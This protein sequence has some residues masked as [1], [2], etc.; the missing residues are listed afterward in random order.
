MKKALLL[1]VLAFLCAA[2]LI[3]PILAACNESGETSDESS[4]EVS[5]A[6]EVK[7]VIIGEKEFSL[8]DEVNSELTED[9]V[10]IYTAESGKAAMPKKDADD[11]N[12]FDAVVLDG[13]VVAIYDSGSTAVIPENGYVIRF[14]GVEDAN[15]NLGDSVE[16][17]SLDVP[18][19]PEKCVRFGDI[20][21]EIGYENAERTAEDTG[22]LYNEHW[23]TGITESNVYCTE[24]AIKDG[25]IVEINRSG[26]DIAGISIPE[27]GYVLVVGQGSINERKVSGLNVGDEAELIYGDNLYTAK[28]YGISGTNRTRPEDGI[29]L[30]TREDDTTTTPVGNNLTEIVVDKNGVMT[31]VYPDCVGM[32]KI[33]EDGFIISATDLAATTIARNAVVGGKVFLSGN[34]AIVI[35]TDPESELVR[36][37]TEFAVIKESFEA[38]VGR[39][40]HI[41]FEKAAGI[42]RE[43]NANI[44][45]ADETLGSS[46]IADIEYNGFDGEVLAGAISALET[47]SVQGRNE[48]VP[49]ITVQDRMAWVT[50]GEYD[51]SNKLMLHYTSQADVDHTVAYAKSIGLNTL[52]IDNLVIGFSVYESEVPG[53]IKLPQ[54]GEL[55]LIEAFKTACDKNGLRLIVMV[56]AFSSGLDKV[57][58]PKDHYMKLY[59]DKYLLTNK[60]NNV[61]ID[62]VI[63]LDPADKDVQAFNLAIISEIVEKYDVYGVQ[64]D[65]MRYPLPNYY[66]EHNYEDFGYN[67][68][69]TSGFIKKYG[70]DPAKLSIT[71]PL[72]EKWCAWR[73]DIISEYQKN[74]YQTVKAINPELHVSFTCFAD[75]RDRQLY[76]YQDVEK[77]A[78]NGYA[79]AILP[80]IYGETTEY[81]LG[82][83]EE[84]LPVTEHTRLVLGVG[85]YVKATHE[86]I[87]EQF[88]MPYDLCA[89]GVA[90]FTL[91]YISICGYDETV[92]NAFRAAAT[93]T[94]APDAE[95]I[96]ASV[97]MIVN[98]VK[99]LKFA[100]EYSDSLTD[101]EGE[102]LNGIADRVGTLTSSVDFDTFCAELEALR[103]SIETGEIAVSELV[104]TALLGELDYIISLN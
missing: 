16:C 31:G 67:E 62:N 38:A 25:K 83:A 14:R 57:V 44:A 50:L 26:D 37:K 30:F 8:K 33:P 64:A 101:A 47:L 27:G 11:K 89:E 2:A 72:W 65:Y 19:Y 18:Y 59:K 92:R 45:K 80:M 3:V 13:M 58:Y 82:Y 1:R 75:Y 104:K 60:G 77:W 43:M 98:R 99:A 41:D 40:D 10:Y 96:P 51:Y 6:A 52:I 94:N 53:I 87:E 22:W 39:L 69:S 73:R 32:N 17:D 81:Q 20:Y 88:I 4:A 7:T 70:K 42:I 29:V 49:Y 79:D 9:G 23:Y 28:R 55:D 24:I 84:I 95:L 12:F 102:A 48:L 21:V 103:T 15:I 5:E 46:D 85:T 68:S 66:Q 56:N 97:E 78:A 63:T 36:L 61:G 93:P 76:T 54:L 34:R 35:V 90:I 74:F 91:R 100:A 86:S 71:D